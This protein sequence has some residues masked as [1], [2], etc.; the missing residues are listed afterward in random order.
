MEEVAFHS[1]GIGKV[2]FCDLYQAVVDVHALR[3]DRHG[4]ASLTVPLIKEREA[5]ADDRLEPGFVWLQ[6]VV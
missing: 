6:V 2:F 4:P 3:V 5:L 1:V